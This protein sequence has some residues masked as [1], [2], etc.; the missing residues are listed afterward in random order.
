[1]KHHTHLT[2]KS[3]YCIVRNVTFFRT[4][5]EAFGTTSPF[6]YNVK[7]ASL[8]FHSRCAMPWHV[9]LL[10]C[11]QPP[12]PPYTHTP[13]PHLLPHPRKCVTNRTL[14]CPAMNRQH[15]CTILY[16]RVSRAN[17]ENLWARELVCLMMCSNLVNKNARRLCRCVP[18]KGMDNR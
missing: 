2:H 12:P 4:S 5:P 13:H 16:D 17:A 3:G 6:C 10:F 1:M 7:Y 14:Q 18:L 9:C 8:S 11:A 15:S